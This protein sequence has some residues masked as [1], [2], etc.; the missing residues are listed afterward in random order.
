MNDL[1]QS[2]VGTQEFS[3]FLLTTV[4]TIVVAVVGFVA[5]RARK[6]IDDH[7]TTTEL[8]ALVGI[9]AIAVTYVEQKF[10]D[11][12]GPAKYAHAVSVANS[13]LAEAGIKVTAQ[14]LQAIIESAVYTEINSAP[15]NDP[16]E[17]ETSV[18]AQPE[19]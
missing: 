12:G 1:I 2:I 5:V 13:L 10:N 19:G 8:N 4:T 6:L 14:E 18:K 9:A 17:P 7:T 16:V 11:L 15:G 3:E